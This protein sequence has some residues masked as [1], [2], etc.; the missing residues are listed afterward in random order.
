MNTEKLITAL[1]THL[2]NNTSLTKCFSPAL[3]QEDSNIACITLLGGT[4]TNNLCNQVEYTDLSLRVLIRGTENDLTTRQLVDE[5]FNQLHLIKDLSYTGG[6]IINSVANLPIY[7]GKDENQR[8]LYNI[9]F[10]V[11]VK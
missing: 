1:R 5:I 6:T 9:T 10:N 11:K 4:T 8:I 7:V 2:I 3:P